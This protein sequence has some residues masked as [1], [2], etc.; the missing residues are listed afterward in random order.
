MVTERL[1]G[2]REGLLRVL[3][4]FS[5]IA[6]ARWYR[7]RLLALRILDLPSDYKVWKQ[8]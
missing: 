8:V 5:T 4:T 3:E 6:G 7:R 1:H 2:K